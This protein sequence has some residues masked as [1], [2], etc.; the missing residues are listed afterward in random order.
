MKNSIIIIVLLSLSSM[1]SAQV[2]QWVWARGGDAKTTQATAESVAS[3]AHGNAAICGVYYASLSINNVVL[4]TLPGYT[5]NFFIAFYDESGSVQWARRIGSVVQAHGAVTKVSIDSQQNVYV[6]GYYQDSA[7]FGD[8]AMYTPNY[9]SVFAAKYNAAG[10]RLWIKTLAANVEPFD[11]NHQST[12]EFAAGSNGAIYIAG[13]F[14]YSAD[15][16]G[17]VLQ[18]GGPGMYFASYSTDG[19]VQKAVILADTGSCT[20][21]C[22]GWDPGSNQEVIYVC[23]Q[24]SPSGN[25]F[26]D[27]FNAAGTLFWQTIGK[28]GY[29]IAEGIAA[30]DN[31][32]YLTGSSG[33]SLSFGSFTMKN[34][35]S[36][37]DGFLLKLT[38][39]G[40]VSWLNQLGGDRVDQ[41]H[42][43]SIDT[44][45]NAYVT[46]YYQ[47]SAKFGTFTL[48]D[49]QYLENTAFFAKYDASGKA[50][51]ALRPQQTGDAFSEA[52]AITA[53]RAGSLV[54]VAGNFGIDISFGSTTLGGTLNGGGFF[55][56]AMDQ[57][58][59]ASVASRNVD[60]LS[61]YPNP[62]HSSST[63]EFD[64]P[65]SSVVEIEMMDIVGRIVLHEKNILSEGHQSIRLGLNDL[66]SGIYNCIVRT[67]GKS[68]GKAAIV[69]E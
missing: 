28:G 11:N 30:S 53:P 61:I 8:T 57:N 39:D 16:Q 48:T 63:I 24:L 56:A 66:S 32:V 62:A 67:D 18:S 12:Y 60:D 33:D 23:G 54:R 27:Q 9:T 29:S 41:C 36:F 35:S 17:I 1:V 4:E 7:E 69:I 51:W 45:D 43:V 42:S 37:F 22:I 38:S 3:D 2:P 5:A 44:N 6:F 26:V 50:I 10:D 59:L 25:L 55:L 19:T 34:Y 20:S 64:L 40:E 15:C 46:G 52:T 58:K 14:Q 47:L 31:S 65:S 21:L 13:A 49:A 68:I